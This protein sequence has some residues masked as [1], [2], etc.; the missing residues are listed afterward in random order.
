VSRE[1]GEEVI[2]GRERIDQ[3]WERCGGG[4]RGW[5]NALVL[6]AADRDLW[7]R[8]DEAM[9]E[10]MA[11]ETVIANADKGALELSQLELNDLRSRAND[12]RESLRT[13]V[14]TAYRWVFYPDE[15]GLGVIALQVP[16]T[17]DERIVT[18]AIKRL[19]D[20]DYGTP[21][22]LARIG[23]VYFNSKLAPHLWKDEG[24]PL[25]LGEISRRFPQWTYLPIL[26][27]REE[28]LRACIREGIAQ[29]LWAV[30]I[31]DNSTSTYQELLQKPEQLDEIVTLFDG[32]ASLVKGDL[33][34][35]IRDELGLQPEAGDGAGAGA[36]S[37]AP[38]GQRSKAAQKSLGGDITP[39]GDLSVKVI[40]GPSQRFTK[41]RIRVEQLG[42]GKTSNLQPYLFKVLQEQDAGAELV[43]TVDVSSAAGISADVLEQRIVEAF[44]QLGIAA[45]WEAV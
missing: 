11:Y 43:V 32:S 34:T 27:R 4:F 20:Q 23:A 29:R 28:T 3:L 19:S 8:A 35:L 25:D 31:G 18:R 22:I 2:V 14:T 38:S 12:K 37:M 45:N 21:K 15:Q 42:I 13:S 16:A 41:L 44:D 30:A 10:V 7:V 40:P 26:P 5:R 6:V 33:L 24:S 17:Q 36:G 9:R 39:R 1:N